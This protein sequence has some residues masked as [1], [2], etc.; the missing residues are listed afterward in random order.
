V[1]GYTA[2]SAPG[3]PPAFHH[4][5]WGRRRPQ[6]GVRSSGRPWAPPGYALSSGILTG[7]N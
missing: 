5:A 1:G 2:R 6:R 4:D 7:P 3:A